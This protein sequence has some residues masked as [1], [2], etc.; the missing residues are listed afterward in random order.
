MTTVELN[1]QPFVFEKAEWEMNI[2][3]NIRP[4]QG[5]WMRPTHPKLKELL[6]KDCF[7][8]FS[9]P[10]CGNVSAYRNKFH[11]VDNLGKVTLSPNVHDDRLPTCRA[12]NFDCIV[13]LDKFHNKPLYCMSYVENEELK[14]LYTH[15]TTQTEAR[16]AFG[17]M[18]Y[19]IV[20][21]APAIGFHIEKEKASDSRGSILKA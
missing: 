1:L 3:G 16:R 14:F 20:G 21:I 9:C 7:A 12:C 19:N 11:K 5:T 6:P 2:D 8:I 17:N 18:N 15:A 13:Y 4:T 10:N